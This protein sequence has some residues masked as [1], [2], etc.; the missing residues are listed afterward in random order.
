MTKARELTEPAF[1]KF[2]LWLHPDRD[3]AGKRY[4]EIRR[5]LIKLLTRWGCTEGEE[6]ADETIDRVVRRAQEMA[7]TYVG[8]PAP[9]FI[10]VARNVFREWL[11]KPRTQELSADSP[12]PD[13]EPDNEREC[14]CMEQCLQ[15]LSRENHHLVREYYREEKQ[16]KIDHRRVLA[17][18]MGIEINALRIRMHRIRLILYQCIENCLMSAPAM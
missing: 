7:D 3:Q 12:Q 11:A 9:Y 5:H 17:V 6:L 15:Q 10:A 4:E 16:A 18:E 8:E 14:E 2:L 13:R 1:D